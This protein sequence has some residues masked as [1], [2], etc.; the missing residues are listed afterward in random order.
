MHQEVNVLS[1][2]AEEVRL[3]VFGATRRF[4]SNME[5]GNEVATLVASLK[6]L[7]SFFYKGE[8]ESVYEDECQAV[9]ALRTVLLFPFFFFPCY[10]IL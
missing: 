5:K 6:T 8:H 2:S 1:R 4:L 9:E 7:A 3:A 10:N